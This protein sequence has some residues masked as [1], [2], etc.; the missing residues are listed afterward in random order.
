MTENSILGP[1]DFILVL[2]PAGDSVGF[3]AVQL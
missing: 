3:L 2:Q 1:P